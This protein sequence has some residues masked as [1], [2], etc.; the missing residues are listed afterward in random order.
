M[1]DTATEIQKPPS[2]LGMETR[3]MTE[4]EMHYFLQCQLSVPFREPTDQ[5]WADRC[6]FPGKVMFARCQHHGIEIERGL[7]MFLCV[8][9]NTPAKLV[10]WVWTLHNAKIKGIATLEHWG[11]YLFPNGVP[12]E[13]SHQ[14]AWDAQ[15]SPKG[16][17]LLDGDTVWKL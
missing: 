6:G 13:E 12:T 11:M 15:K 17:N 14:K 7:F 5:E 3:P 16:G 9:S 8:I 2:L 1:P 4:Q 10:Q